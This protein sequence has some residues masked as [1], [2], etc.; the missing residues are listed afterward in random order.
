MSELTLD[1]PAAPARR[2]I[3]RWSV[4][5]AVAIV[6]FV[7]LNAVAVLRLLHEHPGTN[8]YVIEAAGW[9]HRRLDMS[10]CWDTDCVQIQ[11]LIY[12]VFPPLPALI[13]LPFVAIF[14]TGFAGTLAVAY[15][16]YLLTAWL[17]YRI[18][19]ALGRTQVE[20]V[21]VMLAAVAGS[22]LYVVFL[23]ADTVW[24]FAQIC[25]FFLVTLALSEVICGRRLVTAGAAI[26]AAF[27]C[28]QMSI[29]YLP[30]L[31]VLATPKDEPGGGLT[32]MR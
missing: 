25:A 12:N 19:R 7:A 22:P 24:F 4:L 5:F 30:F 9:L 32:A 3:D 1:R 28:R 8:S 10:A 6:I 21:W 26:G 2:A 18:A 20:A 17:W 13:L 16:I 23:G 27:L 14:G 31:F 11:G 15:A 29:F